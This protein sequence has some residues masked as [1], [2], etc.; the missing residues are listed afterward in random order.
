KKVAA[1]LIPATLTAVF[2]GITEPLEFTF[3]FI[4]PALF[5]L[6]AILGATMVTLMHA[7][8]LVS[9][10]MGGGLIEIAATNWIPLFSNHWDVY[11]AEIVIG[12]IFIFIYY[13]VFKYLIVKFDIA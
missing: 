13:Y 8:G 11:I 9:G 7:F 10:T 4:A 2:A 3:L 5:A 1:L 12:V 6:H